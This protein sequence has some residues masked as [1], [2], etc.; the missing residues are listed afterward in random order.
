MPFLIVL[1]IIAYVDRVN[2]SYAGLQMTESLGFTSEVLGFGLGIFFLG[3]FLFEIPGS[4]I[5]EKWSARKW[6]ARIIISWGI[7]AVLMGFI[8]NSTQFYL[9]RFLLGAAEAGFFPGI[10][11]YLSHWFRYRDRAKAVAMFM[12]AL[13]IANIFASPMSGLILQR[14]DWLGL[15][16]WR[17]VYILEGIPAVVLGVVTIFYLTDRPRDATWLSEAEREWIT[18]ELEHEKQVRKAVRS[19]SIL[20]AF[21]HRNVILLALAYFCAVTSVYGFTFW[22]PKILKGLS[23]YTNLQTITII[24]A[25]PYCV[26]LVSMLI[27]GWSSDRTGERRWH[28]AI[29][30]LAVSAGLFL[31][32]SAFGNVWLA[33]FFF[34]LAGA[35]LY[36]YLPG[37]WALP[38]SFLTESAA[39]ASIGLIN[40]IGN[41][42]GFAG[43]YIVGYL[44]TKTGTFYTGVIYLACSALLGAILILM[45]KHSD[46]V[47][48]SELKIKN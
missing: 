15:P 13:P 26:A 4:L 19:Y 3:Y 45:V 34:C 16:G 48:N 43:G 12:A 27:V 20:E 29:S 32:A 17:W 47:K 25:L 24:A 42:G 41:L 38:A 14:I 10:I 2:V 33:L 21:R 37:F 46:R 36:S 23:G 7:L 8:Q 5:V 31:S 22:L 39:A 30:L 6:L 18:A 1:F 11:V 40:S 44:E 35:G 28:V 9:V